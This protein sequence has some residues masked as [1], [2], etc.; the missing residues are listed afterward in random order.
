MKS[1]PGGLVAPKQ[2]VGRDR[3]IGILWQTIE[4]QSV[5]LVSERRMG[6]TTVIRKMVQESP[7]G[8]QTLYRDVEGVGTPLE[9]VER[10][11]SDVGRL[12]GGFQNLSRKA[13]TL[14]SRFSGA[15]IGNLIKFP[16]AAAPDWKTLLEGGLEALGRA[17]RRPKAVLFWDELP[18]MLSKIKRNAKEETVLDI[19]DALRGQRHMNSSLRMVFTGSIGLHHII[20][21]LGEAGHANASTND[22]RT[23]EIPPLAEE[24]GC[25][26]AMRLIAG[27]RLSCA[28]PDLTARQIS[29]EVDHIP[30]YIHH[31]VSQLRE[32]DQP[33]SPQ[34][35]QE[36]VSKALVDPQDIWDLQHYRDRLSDYYG[37]ER[38]PVVL[39]LL[40][41]LA[42]ARTTLTAKELHS[43]LGGLLNPDAG[44]TARR[45][46]DG[47]MEALQRILLLMQRDHYIQQ[48]LRTG[49]YSYRFSLV[50]RWWHIR[51]NL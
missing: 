39:A 13:R 3:L 19:L 20:T 2:V 16:V 12:M 29:R 32:S 21:G 18:L 9:F 24:D 42:A 15:E 48:Q 38:E 5:V 1:N 49:G 31:V 25:E 7:N 36:L 50:Q 47:N 28:E 26:L 35:V 40:D 27:E 30:Y 46:L 23:V 33:A 51:R 14:I 8:F 22:M 44:K 11:Y 6:K 45:I 41:S 10:V 34:L 4:H 43:R 17:P 37:T